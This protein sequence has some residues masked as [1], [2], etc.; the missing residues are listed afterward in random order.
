MI[1]K[2]FI[3]NLGIMSEQDIYLLQQTRI[4]IAGC[5][6]IGGFTAELLARIGVGSLV[7]ADPDVFDESNINRQCAATF[8]T[9]GINKTKALQDHLWS[10]NPRLEIITFQ[11]GVNTANVTEFLKG[12]DYV[13]DAID[14]FAFAN[15]VMLHREARKKKLYVITAAAIGFGTTV[16][17]FDPNGMTI[18]EYVG[19]AKDLS[20]E[21]MSELSFPVYGYVDRLPSYITDN[22]IS[23]WL[24]EKTIP[25][26]SVG[27]ALGPGVLVSKMILHI[28]GRK[29]PEFVPRSFQLQFEE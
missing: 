23:V 8:Q 27:Q 17:T 14:F 1:A 18:E 2:Q 6:C 4:A 9:I 11:E 3:R 16:L 10:I 22:Q 5:G 24:S 26:I 19:I 21:Q 25:T 29:T 20:V 7:L 28:L 12:V 13:I 15:A